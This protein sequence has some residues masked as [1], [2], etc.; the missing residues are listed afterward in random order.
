ME[1]KDEQAKMK[2]IFEKLKSHDKNKNYPDDILRHSIESKV[3]HI[4]RINN[5]YIIKIVPS[6][7]WE[8]SS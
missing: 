4:L 7:I 6:T 8:R 1:D 2:E 5:I 3:I